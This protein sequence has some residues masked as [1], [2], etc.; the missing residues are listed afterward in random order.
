MNFLSYGEGRT[1]SWRHRRSIPLCKDVI[2]RGVGDVLGIA[3]QLQALGAQHILVPGVPDLGLTPYFEGKGPIAAAT[4]TAYT[5]AFNAQLVAGLPAG[6]WY[7]DTAGLLR[8]IVA[9]PSAYGFTNVTTPCFDGV[10]TVCADPEDY[11]FWDDFHPTTAGHAIIAEAFDR[12]VP[13]PSSMVLLLTSCALGI[14]ARKRWTRNPDQRPST[15]T[16]G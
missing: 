1:T 13:E 15:R 6:V 7:Y 8:S 16:S 10:A 14:A 11:L 12:A 4:A 5:D 2:N 3:S 9:D